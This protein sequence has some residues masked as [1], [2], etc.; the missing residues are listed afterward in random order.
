MPAPKDPIKY[1]EWKKHLSLTRIGVPS[2]AETKQKIS[3]GLIERQRTN[4]YLRKGMKGKHHSEETKLKLSIS[5]LKDKNP[6]WAGDT[7][8]HIMDTGHLRAERWFPKIEGKEKHHIDG[9]P[10]NNELSNI[11]YVTRK[12]HMIFDGRLKKLRQIRRNKCALA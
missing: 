9:N 10:L 2:S 5:K 8:K 3:Q 11:L 7:P 1:I 4:P 6:N 12:E